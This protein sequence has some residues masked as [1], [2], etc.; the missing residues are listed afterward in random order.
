MNPTLSTISKKEM[1]ARMFAAVTAD[2][3]LPWLDAILEQ[4][5]NDQIEEKYADLGAA[6]AM[7]EALGSR[8]EKQLREYEFAIKNKQYEASLRIHKRDLLQKNGDMVQKRIDSLAMRAGSQHWAKLT[9]ALIEA[10]PLCYDGQ[11]LMDTDH[12]S[13]G[14]GS[15]S[16]A[17]SYA[18]AT[19]TTPTADEFGAAVDA[20]FDALI[21]FKDDVGE[22]RN[23]VIN[24]LM[25][26]VP[27]GMR[28]VANVALKAP[29]IASGQSNVLQYQDY[30]LMLVTNP[31]LTVT[32]DF[33]VIPLDTGLKPLIRQ[34]LE[35][36]DIASKSWGSE[37]EYDTVGYH[38]YGVTVSRA[39]GAWSWSSI[40]RT[41]FT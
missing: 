5:R 20:A 21:G 30:E 37:Y 9:S 35:D 28:R 34:Q 36:I 22:I 4:G 17:L 31:R 39:V 19:G 25:V 8:H 6:P 40:V 38:S 27:K 26:M 33:F 7:R 12:V 1:E 3:V 18:A 32:T 11:N 14:S 41:R 10:N 23:D 16:N 24:R 29:F 13:G 2:P 15:Q